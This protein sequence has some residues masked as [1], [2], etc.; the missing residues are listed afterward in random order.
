[1][2]IFYTSRFLRSYKKLL[3][4]IK[5]KIEEKESV[6]MND[7]FDKSLKTHKLH[8]DFEGF[9]SLSVDYKN[10]II[11]ELESDNTIVFYDIGDHDIY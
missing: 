6:I 3:N 2:K 11:F 1:M 5:D 8:G 7:I 10:R 4:E 9:Y